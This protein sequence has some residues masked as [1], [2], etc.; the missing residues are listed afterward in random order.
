MLSIG[1]A[2]SAGGPSPTSDSRLPSDGRRP[3]RLSRPAKA[4]VVELDQR[5]H[6]GGGAVTRL[7]VRTW[8]RSSSEDG[9]PASGTCR[10]GRRARTKL[11]LNGHRLDMGPD[12]KGE[13]QDESQQQAPDESKPGR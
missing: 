9:G 1:L 7:L 10:L 2:G 3:A 5:R 13:Q 12:K 4:S 6:L 8:V 11:P